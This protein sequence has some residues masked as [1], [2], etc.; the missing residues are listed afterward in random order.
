LIP[1]VLYPNMVLYIK[2][3][4]LTFFFSLGYS[5]T[6]YDYMGSFVELS[7]IIGK[8]CTLVLKSHS[9]VMILLI[10]YSIWVSKVRR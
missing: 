4:F 5:C 7:L 6:L 1:N 3:A 10:L 2:D 8:K 9:F